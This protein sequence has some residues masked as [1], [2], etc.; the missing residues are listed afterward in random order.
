[1]AFK[2]DANARFWCPVTKNRVWLCTG[3]L[4]A[5]RLWL[6]YSPRP[7]PANPVVP[8]GSRTPGY[9]AG[10]S[11]FQ[12]QERAC[13]ERRCAPPH[14]ADHPSDDRYDEAN[15]PEP[16]QVADERPA[17]CGEERVDASVH[18]P[19]LVNCRPPLTVARRLGYF[20]LPARPTG[21][22]LICLLQ[23]AAGP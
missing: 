15:S 13:H 11:P 9:A 22:S 23:R 1:M 16:E 7:R 10:G 6:E 8:K 4:T 14:S 19:P 18:D 2:L 5:I 3:T 20:V 12:V 17:A 21:C